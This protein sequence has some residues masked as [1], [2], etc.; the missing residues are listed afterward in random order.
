ME[1]QGSDTAVIY[2]DQARSAGLFE[3]HPF[4]SPAPFDDPGA[5][6]DRTTVAGATAHMARHSMC[7]AVEPWI[8]LALG[9]SASRRRALPG[10]PGLQVELRQPMADG[11]GAAIHRLRDIADR[12][13][14]RDEQP[15]QILVDRPTGGVASR[16]TRAQPMLARPVRHLRRRAP[17]LARDRLVRRALLEPPCQPLPFHDDTNT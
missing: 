11:G 12:V 2:A 3:Q 8:L 1:V 13:A 4:Q 17:E 7:R 9:R 6:A 15:Q 16:M 5:A 10:R 14:P